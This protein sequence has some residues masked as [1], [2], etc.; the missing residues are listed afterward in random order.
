MGGIGSA[1]QLLHGLRSLTFRSRSTFLERWRRSRG[2]ESIKGGKKFMRKGMIHIFDGDQ[3]AE[4]P[5]ITILLKSLVADATVRLFNDSAPVDL[6]IL[7]LS[8]SLIG[9]SFGGSGSHD[10]P[11]FGCVGIGMRSNFYQSS[12]GYLHSRRMASVDLRVW[13][14]WKS[15]S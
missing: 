14:N 1:L 5:L 13:S 9:I 7:E 12:L 2:T 8:L 10:I 11:T 15:S 4:N 3:L 6:G